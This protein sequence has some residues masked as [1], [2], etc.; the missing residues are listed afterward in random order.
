[1]ALTFRTPIAKMNDQQREWFA[2]AMIAMILSDGN[3]SQGEVESLMQAIQSYSWF[4]YFQE[5]I[6]SSSLLKQNVSNL[7][8]RL[9]TAA[10][11]M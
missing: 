2:S 9:L 8:L 11:P 4:Q 6:L 1:M 10:P 3:V 5:K 7:L